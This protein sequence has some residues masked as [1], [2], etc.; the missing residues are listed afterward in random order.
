[1]ERRGSTL[2]WS[3][4]YQF[5]LKDFRPLSFHRTD[6]TARCGGSQGEEVR[7]PIALQFLL[8]FT[9]L[10]RSRSED[11]EPAYLTEEEPP[12]SAGENREGGYVTL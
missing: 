1:M 3:A 12:A 7:R 4:E 9:I 8:L 6:D 10:T 2:I 5:D 11:N